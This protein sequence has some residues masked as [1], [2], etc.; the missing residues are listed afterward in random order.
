MKS[1]NTLRVL[2]CV[3]VSIPCFAMQSNPAPIAQEMALDH[4]DHE[5]NLARKEELLRGITEQFTG[6]GPD[7]VRLAEKIDQVDTKWMAIRGMSK[8]HFAGAADFLQKSLGDKNSAI[9]ANAARALGEL[10]IQR[11]GEPMILMFKEDY[12]IGVLD[13]TSVAL[14]VLH[15]REAVPLIKDK[16]RKYP[17]ARAWLLG[18]LGGIG[19]RD[20][21]AFLAQYLWLDS[22]EA[23]SAAAA[24]QRITGVRFSGPLS[25]IGGGPQSSPSP[26]V[27][28]ARA[29]WKAHEAEYP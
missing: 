11:S 16:I 29:W 1:R 26:A 10:R 19:D 25:P 24:I 5:H 20:D 3:A 15:A 7:L 9:R 2:L 18:A 12:D 28:K 14:V 23:G 21:V 17:A 22:T 8:L 4:F 27:L 6:C 13:Q